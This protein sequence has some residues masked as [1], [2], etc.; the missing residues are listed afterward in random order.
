[1]PLLSTFGAASARSFGGIGAAAAGAG[2]DVDEV[3]ST[4]VDDATGS[5]SLT[6]NNGIDLS[7]EGGIVWNKSRNGTANHFIFDPALGSGAYLQPNTTAVLATG[8]NY[9]FTSTG[10]TDAYNNYSNN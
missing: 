8:A 2:L 1:M 5:G 9:S 3:F 4:F 6:I 7:G 10:L